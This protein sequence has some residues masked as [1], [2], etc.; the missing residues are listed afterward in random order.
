[1]LNL[2]ME[3]NCKILLISLRLIFVQK[4]FLVGF[5]WGE[6]IFVGLIIGG[7]FAFQNGL[8]LAIKK[9]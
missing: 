4:A 6:L 7:N 2:F 1:M 9:A 8:D 3:Y 5:F